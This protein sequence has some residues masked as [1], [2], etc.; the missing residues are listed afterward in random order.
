[1]KKNT[2]LILS[3]VLVGAGAFL[4]Y[5]RNSKPDEK[6][7]SEAAS[8]ASIKAK[9]EADAQIQAEAAAREAAKN[10]YNS[11]ENPNSFKSKIARVQGFLGVAIDGIIGPQTLGA[12]R[13]KL[14]KYQTITLSNIDFILA[15]I[16]AK[17]NLEIN[18]N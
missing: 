6:K 14:P 2:T 18:F 15:D 12:L 16:F 7:A 8:K 11:L 17:R 9:Q 5:N 10:K 1:M 4:I 13:N 3:T